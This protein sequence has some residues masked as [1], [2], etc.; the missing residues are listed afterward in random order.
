MKPTINDLKLLADTAGKTLR[1]A[2]GQQHNVELK[3][4]IDLVTEVD[5][6]I[7]AILIENIR[8]KFPTHRIMAEESGEA[9][10]G[11]H[12][13]YLDPIDG[14]TNFAHNI[15]HFSISIAYTIGGEVQLGVVYDPMRDEMFSAER[16]VGAWLND[17]PIAVSNTAVLERSVLV[18]GFPYDRFTNPRNN[19]AQFAHFALK[20]RGMRRLGSA[21]LDLCYVAAGRV[22]GYWELSLQPYDLAAGW[23]IA[24]EAGALVTKTNGVKDAL[25]APISVLAANPTLYA[26]MFAELKK[27]N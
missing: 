2:Y 21:A 25:T 9:G 12:V 1:A 11:E 16:G 26:L 27:I 4:T 8:E 18:T 10:E 24:A 19:L 23:L 22:D 6:Q 15:P 14:T 3:G 7:E 13:W 17:K 20:V 5:E